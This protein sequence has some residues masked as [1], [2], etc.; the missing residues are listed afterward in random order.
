MTDTL[1]L[2]AD[3]FEAGRDVT[4][5]FAQVAARLEAINQALHLHVPLIKLMNTIR[6]HIAT[7]YSRDYLVSR[8]EF[9][10]AQLMA[11][12]LGYTFVDAAD[13]LFLIK[14][15]RLMKPKH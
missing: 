12:Y 13:L 11:A 15:G 1:Y 10:T 7:H 5:L 8:G 6:H 2:I 4:P 3:G 14:T 9:L